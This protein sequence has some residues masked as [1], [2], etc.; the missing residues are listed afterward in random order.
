MQSYLW[1]QV[2]L[3]SIRIHLGLETEAADSRIQITHAILL[4][5]H[6]GLKHM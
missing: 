2:N 3:H 1:A 6:F 5:H 4:S